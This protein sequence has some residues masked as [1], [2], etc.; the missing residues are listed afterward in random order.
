MTLASEVST[1]EQESSLLHEQNAA[2]TKEISDVR[3]MKDHQD[4]LN[5]VVLEQQ[6]VIFRALIHSHL[7]K[8]S[9]KK[10]TRAFR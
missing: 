4:W 10:I 1:L 5:N 8:V 7:E 6:N 2:P 9:L 3:A